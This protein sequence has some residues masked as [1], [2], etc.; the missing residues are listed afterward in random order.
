VGRAAV[1]LVLFAVTRVAAHPLAPALLELRQRAGG[2][3]DV[4]WKVPAARP[5]RATP[6]PVFPPR[7]RDASAREAMLDGTAVRTRWSI[8]CEPGLAPGD[9][10]GI[11]DVDPAGAV[12]RVRLADG[13]VAERLVRPAEPT[14]TLPLAAGRWDAAAGYVR[15]GI[16][17]ILSGPDHLL[18]VFGLVLLSGR[19]R[20]VAGT[21]TAFTLGHS[22]TLAAA[23]L[24]LV[25]LP[26]PPIEMAIAFS[27]FALAVELAR[28]EG[29]S[30]AMRRHPWGMA[31]L[32]GLLHGLGFAAVLTDAGLVRAD[33]PFALAG[34]N[35]G[36]EAGQLAFVAAVLALRRMASRV[37]IAVPA[38]A[39][40]VPVYAMG[41]LAAYWWLERTADLFR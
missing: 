27:V 20:R 29:A 24:G 3:V 14:F 19:L 13:R 1:V 9:A 40:A 22:L 10:I 32:F 39:R 15:L 34:F 30:S 25:A 2:R 16:A 37:P 18:F 33:L 6:T 23:V 11:R 26:Q 35:V 36:I 17:H 28:G 21:V 8:A 5:S 31:A 12:V 4:E 7:C 38:W 41:T